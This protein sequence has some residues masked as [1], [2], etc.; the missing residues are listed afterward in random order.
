MF[1]HLKRR[2]EAELFS[3][4]VTL[5]IQTRALSVPTYLETSQLY[6]SGEYTVITG[7]MKVFGPAR[8]LVGSRFWFPALSRKPLPDLSFPIQA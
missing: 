7:G 1:F 2:A 3:A 8:C 6:F 5:L 4:S